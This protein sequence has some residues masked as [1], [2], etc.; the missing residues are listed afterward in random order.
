MKNPHYTFPP[1]WAPHE[2]V[3]VGW[4]DNE[5]HTDANEFLLEAVD[6]LSE[7]VKVKMVVLNDSIE[8]LLSFRLDTMGVAPD[9]IEFIRHFDTFL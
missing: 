4:S 5:S 1:E 2:A 7:H 6:I 3:W 9:F 8:N